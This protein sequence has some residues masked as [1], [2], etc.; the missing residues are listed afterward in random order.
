MRT[1]VWGIVVIV[2]VL[3]FP[4]D[5]FAPMSVSMNPPNREFI[6][7]PGKM[8]REIIELENQGEAST[9]FTVAPG[10]FTIAPD[11]GLLFVSS[12]YS[13]ERWLKVSPDRLEIQPADY[14]VV[15][16]EIQVP[17]G[18]PEGSYTASVLIEEDKA[19]PPGEQRAQFQIK[20]RLSHIIYVNVGAPDYKVS[21]VGFDVKPS[22][23]GI[24]YGI[25]VAN[26]GIYY[27]RPKGNIKIEG[28]TSKEIS[29]PTIPVLRGTTRTLEAV[30]PNDLPPGSYKATVT[31]EI[32][33]K[34]SMQM[35]REFTVSAK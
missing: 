35:T 29:V 22:K 23:E 33:K 28:K 34:P 5:C 2:A 14:G 1:I 21:L 19:I 13:A 8:E 11:G 7:K 15:R 18:T 6:M 16:Y 25:R 31:M 9:K 32:E 3:A 4:F 26:N 27:Y 24:K 30:V 10:G 17:E 20:G 12:D